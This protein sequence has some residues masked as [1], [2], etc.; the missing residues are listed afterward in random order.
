V[1][2]ACDILDN[3][4]RAW[5]VGFA[6]FVASGCGARTDVAPS[7]QDL[8]C[9]PTYSWTPLALPNGQSWTIAITCAEP[10]SAVFGPCTWNT[11]ATNGPYD[12]GF[13]DSRGDFML[14]SGVGN[15]TFSPALAEWSSYTSNTCKLMVGDTLVGTFAFTNPAASGDE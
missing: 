7:Q 9:S 13:T 2:F 1:T 3:G 6:L 8:R 14:V 4:G 10:N 12:Y 5:T 15:G 11:G